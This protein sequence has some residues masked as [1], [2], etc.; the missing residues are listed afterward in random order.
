MN[1]GRKA[2]VEALKKPDNFY[3]IIAYSMLATLL[4]FLYSNYRFNVII[5]EFADTYQADEIEFGYFDNIY[6]RVPFKSDLGQVDVYDYSVSY[7][8]FYRNGEDIVVTDQLYKEFSLYTMKFSNLVESMHMGLIV[9]LFFS[10]LGLFRASMYHHFPHAYVLG[11]VAF[12]VHVLF[13]GKLYF[14]ITGI[15]VYTVILAL[16]TLC[17]FRAR[18]AD[19]NESYLL[20]IFNNSPFD[21]NVRIN[22]ATKP[23][24]YK[25]VMTSPD[26]MYRSL[27]YY[28]IVVA[29]VFLGFNFWINKDVQD[30]ARKHHVDHIEYGVFNQHDYP[31]KARTN[32]FGFTQ[33]YT[34]GVSIAKF[35]RDGQDVVLTDE[36]YEEFSD[37]TSSTANIVETFYLMLALMFVF[38]TFNL[39][40]A[41]LNRHTS[42]GFVLGIAVYLLFIVFDLRFFI[43]PVNTPIFILLLTAIVVLVYR[44]RFIDYSENLFSAVLRRKKYNEL[45]A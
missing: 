38:C 43:N 42:H 23:V 31:T 27:A 18:F 12:Y 11:I 30:F 1:D 44:T 40:R 39:I 6:P 33:S 10:F 24:V 5:Q 22:K 41:L 35:Y 25:E 19:Y 28:V 8:K 17:A 36:L 14:N 2:Y 13:E 15:L 26:K 3:K 32:E 34:Y 20:G 45:L 21:K 29:F 7:A 16:M 37:F 9:V 4:I